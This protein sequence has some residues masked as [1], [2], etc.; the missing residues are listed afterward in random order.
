LP[1]EL[2][3]S[4]AF[5]REPPITGLCMYITS[6]PLFENVFGST[7]FPSPK[8]TGHHVGTEDG[9]EMED[10]SPRALNNVFAWFQERG[11][12]ITKDSAAIMATSALAPQIW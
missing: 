10:K 8:P 11:K 12:C 2:D 5:K 7:L 3:S 1:I 4:L 9:V 6:L